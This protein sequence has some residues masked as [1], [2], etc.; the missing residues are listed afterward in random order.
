[1]YNMYHE[2]H[3]ATLHTACT[4]VDPQWSGIQIPAPLQF[5]VLC[6]L[7]STGVN[8]PQLISQAGKSARLCTLRYMTGL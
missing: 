4:A 7:I 3:W 1:M 8:I 6:R 2:D 5:V